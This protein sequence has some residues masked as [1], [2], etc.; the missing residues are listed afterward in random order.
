MTD[1]YK[2]ISVEFLR[3]QHDKGTDLSKI[4][5]DVKAIHQDLTIADVI[6]PADCVDK[7]GLAS[8]IGPQ[9]CEYLAFADFKVDVL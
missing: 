3:N 5:N 8:A 7:S 6:D 2:C 4:F 1:C 9:E